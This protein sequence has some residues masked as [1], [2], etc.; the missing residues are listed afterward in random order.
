MG[1]VIFFTSGDEEASGGAVPELSILAGT[2]TAAGNAETYAPAAISFEKYK[3]E[4]LRAVNRTTANPVSITLGE[5]NDRADA[6][7]ESLSAAVIDDTYSYPSFDSDATGSLHIWINN[8]YAED[9][10]I[11]YEIRITKADFEILTGTVTAAGNA[12]TYVTAAIAFEKYKVLTVQAINR[13]TGNPI[14]FAISETADRADARYE[15]YPAIKTENIVERPFY[16]SDATGSLHMW[17]NNA[18][19]EDAV[20][21]Y[22]IRIEKLA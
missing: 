12:E 6:R 4:A 17:I 18:Y 2:I 9:T 15:N 21:E 10:E 3:V 14:S 20:V 22:E 13:T 19:A 8:S 5:K 11:E 7:Y 1:N 16:D